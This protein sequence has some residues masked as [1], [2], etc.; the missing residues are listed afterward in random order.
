MKT[1]KERKLFFR[2]N[3]TQQL[4]KLVSRLL[5]DRHFETHD[6]SWWLSQGDKV[7]KAYVKSRLSAVIIRVTYFCHVF[8]ISLE[9]ITV[10][11]KSG[12]TIGLD[13]LS[14]GKG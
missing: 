14:G 6:C 13:E 12:A 1:L 5:H 3:P 4:K 2:K 11:T 10:V 8:L 9:V 7:W